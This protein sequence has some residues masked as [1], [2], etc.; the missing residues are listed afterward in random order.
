MIPVQ[1][2][3]W[4]AAQLLEK[5]PVMGPHL[6]VDLALL[7]AHKELSKFWGYLPIAKVAIMDQL[8]EE[9]YNLKAEDWLQL[10]GTNAQKLVPILK[11]AA[12]TSDRGEDAWLDS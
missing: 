3:L 11:A 10:S 6:S 8:V 12:R 1:R 7:R 4:R 5:A 9:G 2:L